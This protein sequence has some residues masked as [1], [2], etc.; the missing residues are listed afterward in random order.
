MAVINH[1][2][3]WVGPYAE[4]VAR[5]VNDAG[6]ILQIIRVREWSRQHKTYYYTYIVR[7]S[8]PRPNVYLP[9]ELAKSR[10]L[11][12][13]EDFALGYEPWLNQMGV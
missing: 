7:G 12:A 8:D 6:A 9:V 5:V 3:E 4:Q 2:N 1:C 13:A 10:S 11:K